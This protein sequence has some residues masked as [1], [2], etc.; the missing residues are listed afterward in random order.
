MLWNVKQAAEYLG[1]SKSM[2]YKMVY[3]K[4]LPC[5]KLCGCVRFYPQTIENLAKESRNDKADSIS[6]APNPNR[7][8]N[9]NSQYFG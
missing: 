7:D 9:F 5:V 2:V 4:V 8:Y 1:I 3:N 6:L